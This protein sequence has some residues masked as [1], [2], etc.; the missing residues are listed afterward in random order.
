[1]PPS[2]R[3]RFPPQYADISYGLAQE[4]TTNTLVPS[5]ASANV[6][7]PTDGSLGTTWTQVGFDDSAWISGATGVGY[8]TAVPGFAVYNYIASV[9]TCS[10]SAA[11]GRY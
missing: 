1:M 7:I 11:Q 6:F 4:V 2:S 3:R 8:E 10:L 5:G 9:G